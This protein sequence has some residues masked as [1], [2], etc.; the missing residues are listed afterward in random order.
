MQLKR[1][2][3][4]VQRH[5]CKEPH[6]SHSSCE[7]REPDDESL[8]GTCSGLQHPPLLC[9]RLCKAEAEV[10]PG[11]NSL[12]NHGVE[13]GGPTGYID[14]KMRA[15]A[16]GW[17]VEVTS[18]FD[19]HQETLFLAVNLLDRFLSLTKV[20]VYVLHCNVEQL[21]VKDNP[22]PHFALLGFQTLSWHE[23]QE[24][25]VSWGRPFQS[26][27]QPWLFII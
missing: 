9:R 6:H 11:A 26:T 21:H 3:A 2:C 10:R 14:G 18:E 23:C 13:F 7:I 20:S 8:Q 19:M 5:G 17:L 4:S 27:D 22:R 16:V 25:Q 12:D 24:V 15:I 1:S